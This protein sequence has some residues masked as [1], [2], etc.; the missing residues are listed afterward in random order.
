VERP[1]V[2]RR[3]GLGGGGGSSDSGS[4][5]VAAAPRGGT[6]GPVWEAGEE[7]VAGLAG[8]PKALGL[9]LGGGAKLDGSRREDNGAAT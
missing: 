6:D 9:R 7:D 1:V 3:Q 2:S 8:P 5:A 4:A